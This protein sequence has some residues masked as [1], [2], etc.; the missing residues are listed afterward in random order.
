MF[1][2]GSLTCGRRSWLLSVEA[3]HFVR[4]P[5]SLQ[6]AGVRAR[7]YE[8]GFGASRSGSVRQRRLTRGDDHPSDQIGDRPADERAR[9]DRQH[10][11]EDADDG[12]VEAEILGQ[13]TADA[14]DLA[15]GDRSRESWAAVRTPLAWG[16]DR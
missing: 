14:G 9:V 4:A 5:L 6:A 7:C 1:F 16:R 15:I 8:K 13:P 11:T 10:H 2:E 12:G 3:A